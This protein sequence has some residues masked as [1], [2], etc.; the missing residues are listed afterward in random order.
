MF[1]RWGA[2]FA[3]SFGLIVVA[4]LILYRPDP[5]PGEA[6]DP[7]AFG[8][9]R[10]P[11]A[12]AGA[13]PAGIEPPAPTE[14]RPWAGG[15]DP[16]PP[17]RPPTAEPPAAP[18]LVDRTEDVGAGL[19]RTTRLASSEAPLGPASRRGPAASRTRRAHQAPFA[20]A[21]AGETLADVARRLYGSGS[22]ESTE[23]LWRANRDLVSRVD[24]P[25]RGGMVLRTPSRP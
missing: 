14:G 2:T 10:P 5:P 17:P 13:A 15:I 7:G 25:L 4:A 6:S 21:E 20:L 1:E 11:D 8:T 24:E 9:G 3:L 22:R 18:R 12:V 19:A 16:S 23:W